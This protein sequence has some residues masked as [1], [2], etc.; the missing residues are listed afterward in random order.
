MEKVA[1]Y[2]DTEN[3]AGTY[4]RYIR[5]CVRICIYKKI[6]TPIKNSSN[7]VTSNRT[8]YGEKKEGMTET[9]TAEKAVSVFLATMF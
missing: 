3:I 2:H 1:C 9:G 7:P 5:V 6:Q 8:E 4:E